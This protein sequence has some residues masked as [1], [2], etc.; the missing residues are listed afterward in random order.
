MY[1][2]GEGGDGGGW[3]G[4]GGRQKANSE[5]GEPPSSLDTRESRNGEG[6][7]RALLRGESHARPGG[8]GE[9][10]DWACCE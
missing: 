5:T 10:E 6:G 1:L 9:D 2:L 4:T 3:E 7:V 8:D